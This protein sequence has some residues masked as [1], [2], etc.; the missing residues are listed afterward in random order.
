[1]KNNNFNNKNFI[2]ENNK[3]NK[4]NFSQIKKNTTCSLFEVEHFLCNLRKCSRYIKL[5]DIFK[6]TK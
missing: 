5:Y 2:Q 3:K 4:F 6:H 1:M